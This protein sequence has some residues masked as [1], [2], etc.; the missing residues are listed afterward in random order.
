MSVTNSS[1]IDNASNYV[2]LSYYLD[3][4][5]IYELVSQQESD[6][7]TDI[8][9]ALSSAQ[10]DRL[11]TALNWGRDQIDTALRELYDISTLT[12]ASAPSLLKN[13][14]AR[15][16]QWMLEKRRLRQG[17]STTDDL[18]D[19]RAELVEL[20]TE[21]SVYSLDLT[22]KGG[23]ASVQESKCS[24]FDSARQFDNII[25]QS[26]QGEVWPDLANDP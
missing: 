24:Q 7:N 1:Y 10:Q 8:S 2:E 12:Y 16:A 22:R 18:V 13:L 19:L 14:N 9:T 20:A 17:E 21:S 5:H 25:P 3:L 15:L 26:D 4:L 11:N 6:T 23:I